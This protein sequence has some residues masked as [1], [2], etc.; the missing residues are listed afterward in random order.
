MWQRKCLGKYLRRRPF[1]SSGEHGKKP[2]STAKYSIDMMSSVG[3][4]GSDLDL[5]LNE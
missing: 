3:T 5:K 4:L 1:L 2:I